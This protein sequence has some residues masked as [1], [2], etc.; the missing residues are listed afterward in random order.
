MTKI[1]I[2]IPSR[3]TW[4]ADFGLSL[5]MASLALWQMS[6]HDGELVNLRLCHVKGSLLPENRNALVR[7]ALDSECTHILWVDD[8]M[9]FPM[10]TFYKLYKH[11][12]DIVGANCAT[13]CI[14]PRP[15]AKNGRDYVF[16]TEKSTGLEKVTRLGTGLLLM[17]ID[18]FK[19]METPYFASPLDPAWDNAPMGEDIY[20]IKK[21]QEMGYEVFID[22]DVSKHVGHIGDFHYTHD[23]MEE[24]H[25]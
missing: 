14:P 21:A 10:D 25:G 6:Q 22:H 9:F 7:Q 20:M 4:K 24:Y 1:A 2:C 5:T 12:V 15:T 3:D 8:D 23:L 19:K 13:K 18:V 17:K 11:D 16:T